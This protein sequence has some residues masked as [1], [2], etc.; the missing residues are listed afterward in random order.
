MGESESY[1]SSS[2]T[3]AELK[4]MCKENGLSVAGRKA[5]LIERLNQFF[6]GDDELEEE[7][8]SLEDEETISLE[9]EESISL[10]E[11]ESVP[12]PT[13]DDDDILEAEV[14]DAEVL[15]ET[16]PS[17]VKESATSATLMDQIKNPKMAAILLTILLATGGWYWYVS[18]QLQPFTADDLRYGD[19]MEYTVLN[20]ELEVTGE[21]VEYIRDNVNVDQ[22]NKSCRLLMT[23]SGIGTTSVTEGGADELDMEPDDSL[24]GVVRAKGAYGLDWLA[25]EKVQTRNFDQIALKSYNPKPLQPD[26]CQSGSSIYSVGGNLEFNTKSWTEISERD[27]I[28]TQ[29]DWKLTLGE[30]YNQGTT[31]SYGLGGV[32]GLLEDIA[33]GVAVVVSPVEIRDMMGTQLIEEGTNGTHLGWE[34]NVIGPDEVD[35]EERWKVSMENRE[36]RD[37]C[38]GHARI[39]MWVEENSPWAVKQNVDVYISGDEGDKSACGT[40]TERLADVVLPDGKISLSL[41]ISKNSLTRGEKLLDLGRSYSSMPNAGAYVPT[42][43]ELI[44]WGDTEI[45]MP[46]STSIRSHSLE[47]AVAC[48]TSGH[49][50]EAVAAN[51]ALNDDGYIWRARDDRSQSGI[52]TW[53]LSWVSSDPN[54]GWVEL[55]V[56]GAAS[57]ANCTYVAH[58]GHDETVA[59]SRGDI[60]A[61]LSIQMMEEDL[62]D[63][64]RYSDVIGE[65]GLF[66]S[67]G[68]Y[69]PETRVGL[70]VVTPDSDLTEWLSNLDS[71]DTGATTLDLTRTWISTENG[72]QWDNSLSLAMD[73]RTGQVVGW[74][75]IQTP[76]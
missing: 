39:T 64:L 44:D 54:S 27:V 10:E 24:I 63:P 68:E 23:F 73:A 29:A 58:G 45:H 65:N 37:N 52:T 71:G 32:L 61:V 19:S 55:D 40:V 16:T 3:V 70:L 15:E 9:S 59:H 51:S 26:E 36:I 6:T 76:V 48:L 66:T 42:T 20:G 22:L 2:H 14:I 47:N 4:V 72:L 69:H 57:A 30:D 46:D 34:W 25:V 56:T 43:S 60:P 35:G 75:L 38:F 21:Y 7:I 12:L 18:N 1:V 5:E 41:E 49:V 53:N 33:P 31:K 50:S 11:S 13:T 67:T 17:S 28:S 62:T 74:N 8:I